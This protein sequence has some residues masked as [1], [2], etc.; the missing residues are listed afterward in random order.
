MAQTDLESGREKGS[1]RLQ[2]FSA[3]RNRDFR[4]LW[5][6]GAFVSAGNQVQQ[7]A[8]GWLVLQLTDSPFRVGQLQLSKNLN[9]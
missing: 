3:L 5:V 6:S 9:G 2:T 7:I 8:L 4:Y 1:G